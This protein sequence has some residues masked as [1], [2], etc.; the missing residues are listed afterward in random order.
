[1]WAVIKLNYNLITVEYCA[2]KVRWNFNSKCDM[3]LN[4]EENRPIL[5]L[6]IVFLLYIFR[7]WDIKSEL[8]LWVAE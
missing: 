3:K 1:M 7:K 5:C 6:V 2:H 8:Y 4:Q